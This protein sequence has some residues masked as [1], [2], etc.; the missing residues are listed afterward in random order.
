MVCGLLLAAASMVGAESLR[1]DAL[2]L[3]PEA[4]WRR[5]D[6]AREREDGAY[7]LE[8]PAV[9]GAR[10]IALQVAI[11]PGSTPL[12]TD[13]QAFYVNLR[14]KWA[15][16]Y[17]KQAE[18]GQIEIGGMPWL[19]CRRRAGDGEATVFLLAGAHGGRAYS[20]LAF[21][22]PRATG[23]PKPVYDLLA[24]ADFGEAPPRGF[25][26]RGIAEQPGREV[27]ASMLSA[28]AKRPGPDGMLTGY[29]LRYVPPGGFGAEPA[30]RL[31]WFLEGFA[32]RDQGGREER[33]PFAHQ[34]YLEARAGPHSLYLA[35]A[36]D[37]AVDVEA[38]LLD[39]CAPSSELDAAL[40]QLANGKR[41]ALEGL[42]RERPSSCPP[43]MALP[44]RF[45]RVPAG[46]AMTESLD[47]PA[48]PPGTTN[49]GLDRLRVAFLRPRLAAA[50]GALG[51]NL[52]HGAG[53][54][55]IYVRE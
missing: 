21:A 16:Q 4:A 7:L 9:V 40:A 32:W 34:G 26:R 25:A 19:A 3:T 36:S 37:I 11:P 45:L 8:W 49:A 28:D 39:L 29:G 55:F 6:P 47:L 14:K 24:T 5:G 42:L 13:A 51:Q 15:S 38:G 35:A 33:K 12:R 53:L 52:L 50:E 54:Y 27:L 2:R 10:D 44:S 23:L 46:R 41:E 17:G 20:V 22:A 48:T 30:L 43:A 1:V 31:E 18:I